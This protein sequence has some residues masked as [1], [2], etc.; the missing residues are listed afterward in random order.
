MIEFLSPAILAAV[1]R[2]SSSPIF[3]AR[4]ATASMRTLRD[5]SGSTVSAAQG[6]AVDRS[7]GTQEGAR[8]A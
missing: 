1:L 2:A 5:V 6:R 4:L 7:A 8:R 3:S